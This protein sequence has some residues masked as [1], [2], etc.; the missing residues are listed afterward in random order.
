M[1]DNSSSLMAKNTPSTFDPALAHADLLKLAAY[2]MPYGKYAGSLLIDL[3]EP[4]VVWY[5]NKGLPSGELGQ[6][7]AITYEIK[8]NGLESLFNPLKPSR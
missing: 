1:I 2:R 8:T 3:P 5:Y 4:Y 7:L 6:M